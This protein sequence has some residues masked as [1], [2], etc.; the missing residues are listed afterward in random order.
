[1]R[2]DYTVNERASVHRT[3]CPRNSTEKCNSAGHKGAVFRSAANNVP[4]PTGCVRT[5][6]ARNID[7]SEGGLVADSTKAIRS[8][9]KRRNA[10]GCRVEV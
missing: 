8:S 7:R 3:K 2:E 5:T 6:V 4:I 1:M 10:V 9:E